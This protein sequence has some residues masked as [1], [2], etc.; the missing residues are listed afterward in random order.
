M[1]LLCFSLIPNQRYETLTVEVSC[2]PLQQNT[3]LSCAALQQNTTLSCAALQQ[4]TT[5]L[6]RKV[7]QIPQNDSS[8]ETR[9]ESDLFTFRHLLRGD[10]VDLLCVTILL[11]YTMRSHDTTAVHNA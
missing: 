3:T 5:L 7:T 1:I 9:Q 6:F 8:F 4:N 11:Q 10:A 2:A